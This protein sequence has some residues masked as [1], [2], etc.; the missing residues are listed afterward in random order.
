MIAVWVVMTV[1]VQSNYGGDCL[2]LMVMVELVV[3]LVG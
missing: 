2:V 3:M 1:V